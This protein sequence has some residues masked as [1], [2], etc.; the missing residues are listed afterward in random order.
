ML[1]HLTP[2]ALLQADSESSVSLF[3]SQHFARS[4]ELWYVLHTSCTRCLGLISHTPGHARCPQPDSASGARYS[5]VAARSC[6]LPGPARCAKVLQELQSRSSTSC[7]LNRRLDGLHTLPRTQQIMLAPASL[8]PK[9]SVNS[10]TPLRARL[11]VLPLAHDQ[12][13][14]RLEEIVHLLLT[15]TPGTSCPLLVRFFAE[16][17][18]SVQHGS[19]PHGASTSYFAAS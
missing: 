14:R 2:E 10:S 5:V 4:K 1:R 3:H 18:C 16:S 17:Q 11:R 19:L 9:S 8:R 6:A 7:A 13:K 15:S 12:Y